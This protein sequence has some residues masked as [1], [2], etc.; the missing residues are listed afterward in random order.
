MAYKI[1]I[2]VS[3]EIKTRLDDY[4]FENRIDKF[5]TAVLDVLEAGLISI[6][7][8]KQNKSNDAS[9]SSE[10]ETTIIQDGDHQSV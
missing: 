4:R 6:E 2:S 3:D 8:N 1:S 10:H 7:R 9:A 5:Q